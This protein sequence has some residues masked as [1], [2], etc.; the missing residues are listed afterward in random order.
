MIA[1]LRRRCVTANWFRSWCWHSHEQRRNSAFCRSTGTFGLK[2]EYMM[3]VFLIGCDSLIT[4]TAR[5]RWY[6]LRTPSRWCKSEY[7]IRVRHYCS[8]NCWVERECWNYS[9]NWSTHVSRI[10]SW[11]VYWNACSRFSSSGCAWDPRCS[12]F[13]EWFTWS[14][15]RLRKRVAIFA[16]RTFERKRFVGNCQKGEAFF[17]Y[18][19]LD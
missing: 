19:N 2:F 9:R 3:A 17:E 14:R 10:A 13:S 8:G 18:L 16:R 5:P 1:R 6:R 12:L 11:I 4:T 15:T 7:C